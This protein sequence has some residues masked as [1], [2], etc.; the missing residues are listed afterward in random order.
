MRPLIA[1]ALTA[2]IPHAPVWADQAV[3]REMERDVVLRALVDELERGTSGLKLEDLE[4]PY[5]IEY[6]L[7]DVA[8]VSVGADLGAVAS[9]SEHRSRNLR[10]G[11]RVGSYELDNTNFRGGRY[12]GFYFRGRGTHVTV[13][14]ED[15]YGAIRQAVWWATDRQYKQVAESFVQKKAFMEA[16]LI[17]DKPDD[18][19]RESPAVY[20]EDRREVAVDA[21]PLE[22]LAVAL[23]AI[24]REYPDVQNSHVR[25]Q[26]AAGNKYLVNSEGS[27][28]RTAGSRFSVSVT[29]TVQADDGMKLSNSLSAHS[30]KRADLPS[31]D[32]LSRRCREMAER[33][34][35][36]RDAPTLDSYSGPVLFEPKAATAMFAQHFGSRF[37]GGQRPVGSG[38]SVDDFEN[39]LDRRILPRFL[40]V[41]DDPT[42]ET[43]ADVQVIG[44][45]VYD[46]QAVKARPVTLVE[47]GRL[48]ALLMS[49]NPSKKSKSSTGHGRGTYR[50]QTSV[51]CLIVTATDGADDPTLRQELI[52]ACA[53]EGL[54]FG[55]RIASLGSIGGTGS[56]SVPLVMYKVYPD[57]HEEL[58]RGTEIARVDL[59]AFKRLLA[60]GDTPYVL[61][62]ATGHGGRTVS[63]PAILFEELDLAK[64]DRDF[65]RPPILPTPLARTDVDKED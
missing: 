36:V 1:I 25:I 6:Q 7:L 44:H 21:A 16:K 12:G 11:V 5:F 22:K 60:A 13:P 62:S 39:K 2:L 37:A 34:L 17:E 19:S 58:V 43:I 46:D 20:F 29:A 10:T 27:R 42:R 38:K 18:F 55:I 23:S 4:R 59:K 65:D 40:N 26:G 53:D 24:F 45:Y 8:A 51:G 52:E 63:A 15:D 9:K 57:G 61:N 49:R 30:R 41:T 14:T 47:Q 35:A 64:A 3:E 28:L 31:L 48:K 33:L 56:G 32:E 50:P 54:E